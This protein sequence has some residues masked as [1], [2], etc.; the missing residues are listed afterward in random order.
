MSRSPREPFP[1]RWMFFVLAVLILGGLS[2]TVYNQ[3]SATADKN[4]AQAN[5]QSLAQDIQSVC[6]TQGR[7]LVDN[8]DLCVKAERVQEN[9]TEAIPGPKGDP[10]PAGA[11]GQDGADSTVP[12]PAGPS[13]KPGLDGSD[14]TATGPQG[15]AGPAGAD[16]TVPGPPGPAGA[17]GQDG[18]DSTVPGPAGPAGADGKDGVDGKSPE[19]ITFTDRT[20]TDLHLR[21]EPTR[22]RH[23]YLHRRRADTMRPV[24]AEFETSQEFGEGATAGVAPSWTPTRSVGTS[25]STATTRSSGTPARTSSARSGP[26]SSRPLTGRSSTPAGR[27]TCRAPARFASG[28]CTGTSAASSP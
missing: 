10:G 15:P 24:S 19:S 13:G 14:S 5:S 23:V 27:K 25:G 12:G 8:R 3:M 2:W 28:S 1:P 7:L 20:G 22:I 11:D 18:A 6:S 4:T 17:D 21:A 26:R 16:S 9:P